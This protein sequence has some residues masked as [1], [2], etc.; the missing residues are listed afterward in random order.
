MQQT[1]LKGISAAGK[2]TFASKHKDRVG[3]RQA[4]GKG[5][6]RRWVL[7]GGV[8]LGR[9]REESNESAGCVWVHFLGGGA[10]WSQVQSP[11]CAA[12]EA[13]HAP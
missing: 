3:K 4:K 7:D 5:E 8:V 2:Q 6:A 13:R 9:L 12:E 10:V 11:G 1:T